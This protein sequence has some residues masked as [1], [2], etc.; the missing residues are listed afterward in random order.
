[1]CSFQLISSGTTQETDAD[2]CRLM[3]TAGCGNWEVDKGD[4]YVFDLHKQQLSRVENADSPGQL[5]IQFF[6][7]DLPHDRRPLSNK[8]NLVKI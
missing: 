8:V 7:R 6:E 2:L 4:E 3:I 1:M 5:S